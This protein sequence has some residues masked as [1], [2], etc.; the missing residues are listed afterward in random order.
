DP[1]PGAQL[2]CQCL[3]DVRLVAMPECNGLADVAHLRAPPDR[4]LR[5][6][7]EG[8]VSLVVSVVRLEQVGEGIEVVR[9]FRDHATRRSHVCG[10]E[11]REAGIATEDPEYADPL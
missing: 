6:D 3:A 4:A 10:V 5:R 2:I 11:G 7:D 8:I 1:G 9:G